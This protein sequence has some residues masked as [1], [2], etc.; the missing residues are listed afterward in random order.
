MK[1]RTIPAF[2]ALGVSLVWGDVVFGTE[3]AVT[4]GAA[5]QLSVPEVVL[6]GV[7]FELVAED[8]SGF[9]GEQASLLLQVTEED[10][11]TRVL[12]RWDAAVV[13]G[14]ATFATV[15]LRNPGG[16]W[17]LSFQSAQSVQ[18]VPVRLLPG[19]VSLLPPLLAIGLAL[20]TRQ[21]YIALLLGIWFG[22]TGIYGWN[23]LLGF[24]H[25]GDRFLVEALADRSHASI[26]IFST[27][28]GGMVGILSHAGATEG[29][30]RLLARKVRGRRGGQQITAIMGTVIFFDDYAN[31]LLVGNSMRPLTDRLLISREKLAYLVDS[32][33]A[34]IATI[35]IIST[36]VG[37][38]IGLIQEALARLESTDSAYSLFLRS[39]PYGFYPIFTILFVYLV[40][41]LGRDFGPMHRAETRAVTRG[42]LLRPGAQPAADTNS[43]E[44]GVEHGT[45]AHP[46]LAAVPILLVILVTAGGLWWNGHQ[47]LVAAGEMTPSFRQILNAADSFAV[48]MWASLSGV[49]AAGILVIVSRRLTLRGTVEGWLAGAKAMLI[50]MVILL[51]AWSLSAVCSVLG[52]APFLVELCQQGLAARFLPAVTFVLAAAVS[53]ATGTSWGTMAIL[54]PLVF[55]LGAIL[56]VNEGLSASTGM[57][58]HLATISAVLAG[59]VFGDHCSPI[60]DTT[61]LSS[62]ASGS[63]HMDHVRTQLPYAVV[64]AVVALICGYIPAGFGMPPVYSLLLGAILLFILLRWFGRKAGR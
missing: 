47:T 42:E 9:P 16:Q 56:P 17:R 52:T 54:M 3:A 26:L 33:A 43:F 60:S 7:A 63:D 11:T 12:E 44:G 46:A 2:L 55:P 58:I 1:A 15:R 36:W 19:W 51:L 39:I 6:S 40:A 13:A 14:K 34:P 29:V 22:V 41:S 24:L 18:D 28:L 45:P 32:T 64:V 59:A 5:W 50:A 27:L 10:G 61:I 21:V 62:L 49:L 35:A 31:T 30:V 37:F 8:T 57:N 53:F 23:P 48:L 4:A 38:E 20:L 25:L